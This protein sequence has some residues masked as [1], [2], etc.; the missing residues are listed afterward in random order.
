MSSFKPLKAALAL[1]FV[2]TVDAFF[3]IN[4]GV[5]QTGRVDSVVNPGSYA[6]HAHTLVGSANIGV[7][8]TY[9]TLNNS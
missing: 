1:P 8:S 2:A 6:E 5:I 4:C 7:N 9:E 3:R